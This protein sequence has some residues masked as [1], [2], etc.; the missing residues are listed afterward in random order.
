MAVE[1]Y[2][3]LGQATVSVGGLSVPSPGT[4]EAWTVNAATA[5]PAASASAV[6][7]TQFHAADPVA[8]SEIFL[9]TTCP[10]GTGVQS[11]SVTRGSEGT[12]PVAHAAGFTVEQV[13]TSGGLGQL[14]GLAPTGDTTGVA[15]TANILGLG[16]LAGQVRLQPGVFYTNQPIVNSGTNPLIIRGTK[17]GT[18]SG[19]GAGSGIG[20]VIKPVA[21]WTNPG[22]LPVTAVIT[23]INGN[24]TSNTA[25]D[26][27][28]DIRDV[29]IDCSA[30]PASVDA[31]GVWGAMHGLHVEN[32]GI[33]K[34]TGNGVNIVKNTNFGSA[35]YS[36]GQFVK[37]VIVQSGA[38]W[39]AVLNGTDSTWLNVHAQNCMLGGF[40]VE[41][42]HNQFIGCR[43]DLSGFSAASVPSGNHAPGWKFNASTGGGYMD[44]NMIIGGGTQ[45]NDGPGILV[46]NSSVTGQGTRCP[47][48]I[49]G[50]VTLD[51]DWV[52][53]GAGAAGKGAIQVQGVNEVLVG[54]CAVLLHT[55]DVAGG[56]PDYGLNTESIGTGPGLPLVVAWQSGLINAKVGDILDSAPSV[57][58]FI[59]PLVTEVIGSQLAATISKQYLAKLPVTWVAWGASGTDDIRLVRNSA[60][61]LGLNTGQ[62]TASISPQLKITASFSNATQPLLELVN[63]ASADL[64]LGVQVTG[65]TSNRFRS[66][67]NGLLKWGPGNA[68]QDTNLYR[69]GAG[70]LK[71]DTAFTAGGI[72]SQNAGTDSA[73]SAPVLTPSF[74]N[75]TAAQLSDTTR[76]YMVYLQVGVA[77]TGF[78]L[79][80]GPTSTP[81]NTIMASA[82]PTADE[83]LS[84]RLPAGWYVKWAGASTTLTT[85]TAVGC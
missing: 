17:G 23:V 82:T 69:A 37:N 57:L 27:A 84:F 33:N 63:N 15:D 51:G 70:S 58:T 31:I 4:V 72:I 78:T 24:G 34:P 8:P 38:G 9:V 76:D 62:D 22:A 54:T 39:G 20:T 74:A 75:G 36:L 44:A 40:D 6:P 19:S 14:S 55:E 59:G 41:N 73:A 65:D 43:A 25:I 77:G 1:V 81:A 53:G 21:G 85:Q 45:R 56:C 42:A 16:N 10:G 11:W 5:F 28:L 35:N 68:T 49:D 50:S 80:I 13:I 83:F 2:T 46:T 7:P 48:I 12:A 29:W 61:I 60:G 66:D 26:L 47:V 79:A 32:V 30:A 18:Q 64:A 67:S 71:T 52:N 3:D